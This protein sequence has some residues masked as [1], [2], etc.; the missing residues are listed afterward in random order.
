MADDH[1]EYQKV[2]SRYLIDAGAA[3]EYE[4]AVFHGEAIS[5]R[6]KRDG[7]WWT[8]SSLKTSAQPQGNRLIFNYKQPKYSKLAPDFGQGEGYLKARASFNKKQAEDR[9]TARKEQA[10]KSEAFEEEK[11]EIRMQSKTKRKLREKNL[12]QPREYA[13]GTLAKVVE[14]KSTGL[15]EK[16]VHAKDAIQPKKA[17]YYKK[18]RKL[19]K[20]NDLVKE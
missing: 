7:T 8:E 4:A 16:F 1:K 3:N 20:Q 10:K 17:S 14:T 13:G 19:A 15:L 6:I 2:M 11:E 18:K 5:D 12:A 9:R